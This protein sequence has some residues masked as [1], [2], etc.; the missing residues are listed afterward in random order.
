[1]TKKYA[2]SSSLLVKSSQVKLLITSNVFC[3]EQRATAQSRTSLVRGYGVAEAPPILQVG[4]QA[5]LNGLQQA[6]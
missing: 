3:I 2:A 4:K 6:Q 1:M 5:A